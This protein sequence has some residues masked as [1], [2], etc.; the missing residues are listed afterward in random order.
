MAKKRSMT[1]DEY[2][3]QLSWLTDTAETPEQQ[4]NLPKEV[5][6][7]KKQYAA[8][9]PLQPRRQGGITSSNGKKN[10]NPVYR[11]MGK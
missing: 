3:T 10:V 4:K 2:Y 1:E 7:L 5:A 8:G 9:L 11:N 6:A